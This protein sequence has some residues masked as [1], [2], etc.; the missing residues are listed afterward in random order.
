LRVWDGWVHD[1]PFWQQMIRMY[2]S[3]HD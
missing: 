2:I 3:G 1:W